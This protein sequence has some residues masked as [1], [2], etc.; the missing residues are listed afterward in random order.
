MAFMFFGILSTSSAANMTGT[1]SGSNGVYNS[2]AGP[3]KVNFTEKHNGAATVTA[4]PTGTTNTN[5]AF[6]SNASAAGHSSLEVTLSWNTLT[7]ANNGTIT[8]NFN[9]PVN[10]P[11]LYIDRIGG[12]LQ[13][14]GTIT[15]S[16]ALLTLLNSG[17]YLTKLSGPTS[18]E[19]TSSTIQR[20]PGVTISSTSTEA[21]MDPLGGTAA[22]TVQIMGTNI[23]SVTFSWWGVG[24]DSQADGLEF[25]WELEAPVDLSISKSD[26]P[27]PV[28]AGKNLTY[29]ITVHNNGPSS[30][31]SSDVFTVI[32][33]LPAGFTATSYTPSEG[34]YN[35]VTGAWTGV[36]LANGEDVTLTIIGIVNSTKTGTLTNTASVQVPSGIT[37]PNTN[38]NQ[39]PPVITTVDGL[40]TANND[41]KTTPE[42]T[43]ISG[44]LPASDPDGPVTVVNFVIN[45]T[46]YAPGT[47]NIPGVGKIVINSDGSYLFTPASNYNGPVPTITYTASDNTGN[48]ATGNLNINVTPVNDAP[49]GT[50]DSKT[51]PEDTQATGKVTGTDVDGDTLTFAKD[52]DPS[53]GTVV[54]NA[55]GTYTYMPN[56]NYNGPDSFTVIVSDGK[57]G[58]DIV[59]VNINVTP[60]NDAPIGNGDSKTIPEDTQATGKVT[61][62]DVD[63][64]ILT[65]TKNSNPTHGTV[66]VNADGT[67]TYMPNANYNGPDSFTVIVSDGN[68]GTDTVTVTINVTPVNDAPIGTGDSKAIPEDTQ[69]TGKV[70]GTDVD[71]D[72]LTYTKNSNPTHGTAVVNADGTY[73]YTPNANYN[74]PDSF[75][76]IVSDGNGGSDVVTV[77]IDVTPVNDAPVGTGDSKTIPEDTQA[78]GKVTGTDV[79]GDTLTY[80]KNT[81]PS[82]GTAVVNA[83]GTYTY[84]PN[85]NYNGPDS[86]TV[87]VSDGNGG[88]DVVTV[89]ID[90]TPVNDAPV[91]T[92]DSKTIPED[93][94]ATGKV[95]GTDVDGDTLTYTKNTDP[96][97]G[98]AVVNADGTYTYTPNANYNGPDSFTVTVSDGN[99]GTDTVT[100]TI[101]VTPVNDAPIGNDD[102]KTIP[103]DTQAT[104]KVTGT[105]VDGDTL[106]YTKNSNPSHG[107]AVVNADGT[108]TYTPNA[109]YNGPDSFTIIVSD[110]KGGSDVVTVNI[111]VTPVNDAPIGND[112]SKTIPEDTQATGNVTGTDVDGD[113]LT[114]TKSTDPSHGT[115]VVNA[116][117]T[118]TYTPNANYNGPDSFTV[119]VSDGNGGSDVVTVNI[120]VTPVNDAPIGNDDSKTIPEDTQATGKV[121]GTDI[122]GDTLTYTKNTNP[123]HGTAVVNADG[124]YTYTPNANYNGPDSFTVTVSDGNGGSDVVTVTIDVMPVNDAPVGT[125]DSQTIPEDTQATGKVTG[126]DVDGDTLTYTKNTDPSHGT[127]VVNADGT[128]TYTPNANYNGPDSFTVTV[129]D[130]NGGSDV[131][132][133]TIDVTPVNDAPVGTGDSKTIP[134]DTQATGK[135]IGTDVD[136]DTL[137]YTKNSNPS[138][139]TAVVNADGTYTYTPNANYNGPDSFTIIVSDGKGGSDVVTVTIDVT[140]V[141]D[142]P[143][144]TGDSQ[145]IPEDT[146]ATGKVTGTDVDGDTLTYTKNTN[147]THGTVV[148]NADGTYTYTPNANYNGP[149]SFTI[150]V[151]DGKGGSDVVLVNITMTPVD[152]PVKNVTPTKVKNQTE[153]GT[154]PMQRTGVPLPM[155]FMA[156]VMIFGAFVSNKRK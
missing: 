144:G 66:V 148:V 100:V 28:V 107:T 143:V 147:P 125:G 19:V 139:G 88:S 44:N 69:A 90:V 38:N 53:H 114:Y 14:G 140:P 23:T 62:T 109:N 113:T 9:R 130:G 76:I 117:G 115:A 136:G 54:V 106:T 134:E 126:T 16:S 87:T 75:T 133:V 74:G 13:N 22:G 73:T 72:T 155:L 26:S 64:D 67:Y 102:S 49:V 3:V 149:D 56:A 1:W 122:D 41:S 112:D 15:S 32:D 50:G 48:T 92:G 65:Y 79:D 99:G 97:H 150:I 35:P 68:G 151:S 45:G 7:K 43:P 36:T 8:F 98:T 111:N 80:T 101:N 156:L 17:M 4:T 84:T 25:L 154:I 21:S 153:V 61:G 124:T 120:N 6:W 146:Q 42:D 138:H 93:T 129:S 85:A 37:D 40:P 60:V 11:I 131:V 89:T 142:A 77:T 59:T 152:D 46:T 70:T 5:T 27:D 132:T 94:Q 103:E 145:T 137:T 116:D 63:G 51:T 30:I 141:N 34:S 104:G 20:T 33:N 95:T 86:F 31:I 12:N 47:V 58:S 128:Y 55:D 110:G 10:N 83:D 24:A 81:N 29:T 121:T 39:A 71:G 82:H 96:S 52:T 78:T 127:A 91:G 18:F 119:T 123:S 2:T 118:Y 105:D 108:Y 135:V 57:G